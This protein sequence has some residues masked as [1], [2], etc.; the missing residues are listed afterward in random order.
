MTDLLILVNTLPGS[1]KTTLT[2]QL[3]SAYELAERCLSRSAEVGAAQIKQQFDAAFGT[4]R[5]LV[6]SVRY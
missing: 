2:T 1:G 4:A 5:T 3:A 6:G